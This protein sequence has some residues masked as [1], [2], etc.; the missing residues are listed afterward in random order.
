MERTRS[1]T[2]ASG[3]LALL[4]A[5][6]LGLTCCAADGSDAVQTELAGL[7]ARSFAAVT[8]I[9]HGLERPE[10]A[11]RDFGE[12]VQAVEA[13]TRSLADL[14]V[15]PRAG[16]GQRLMA[17]VYQARAW[18]DAAQA[19]EGAPP[20]AGFDAGQ[21]ALLA[22][23]LAEKAFPAKVAAKNSYERALRLACRLGVEH[24]PVT[25]E[26]LDGVSRYGG[27]APS[28]DRACQP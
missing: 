11:S 4:A 22:Q 27:D 12:G 17:I 14:E 21:Q 8:K 28:P 10:L 18:D 2:G 26:I 15:D 25:V 20:P 19:I 13:T 16:D 3:S 23:V 24:L 7:A 1:Q 9:Q 6:A 5:F